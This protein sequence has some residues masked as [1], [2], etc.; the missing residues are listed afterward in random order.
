MWFDF[1]YER[2]LSHFLR[3]LLLM[4]AIRVHLGEKSVMAKSGNVCTRVNSA[5]VLVCVLLWRMLKR[6]RCKSERNFSVLVGDIMFYLS[7]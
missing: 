7:G 1:L 2:Q 6:I 3:V 5:N 4:F